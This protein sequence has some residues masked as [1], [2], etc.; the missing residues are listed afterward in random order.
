MRYLRFISPHFSRIQKTLNP[1]NPNPISSLQSR[2]QI[3]SHVVYNYTTAAPEQRPPPSEA[4]SAIADEISGLT[5]LEV[6]DLTEVLREKLGVKEMPAMVM[7]MPGMGFGGLRGPGKGGAGAAKSEEKAEKLVFDV[8][9]DSFDA[10]AKIKVIKE[11]RTFT[12]LGLKEA[13][14]LVEKA[15]T[16]LKKGVTKDEAESIVAKMKEVGAKVSME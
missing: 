11:V 12:D 10:A 6:S 1:Q 7:M 14:D 3:F 8:K 16:L 4:V 15:P 2:P 5:L 13:K 9:L